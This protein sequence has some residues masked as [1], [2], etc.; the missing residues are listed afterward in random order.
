MGSFVNVFLDIF[1]AFSEEAAL[2]TLAQIVLSAGL[3]LAVRSLVFKKMGAIAVDL[4]IFSTIFMMRAVI[5]FEDFRWELGM[6]MVLSFLWLVFVVTAR[7]R[8]ESRSDAIIDDKIQEF[9]DQIPSVLIPK[10]SHIGKTTLQPEVNEW[11]QSNLRSRTVFSHVLHY[12]ITR[13]PTPPATGVPDL[14]GLRDALRVPSGGWAR[15]RWSVLFSIQ[16]IGSIAIP[17]LFIWQFGA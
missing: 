9:A 11:R 14:D 4:G 5:P 8:L 1:K 2:Q 3:S 16:A 17:T 12:F 6:G 10:M 7:S 15:F 13:A